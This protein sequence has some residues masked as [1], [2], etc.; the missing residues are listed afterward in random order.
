LIAEPWDVGQADSYDLG[1]FP[2]LWREWNGRYRD[3]VRDFLR[4]PPGGL[5]ELATRFRASA[6]LY[7]RPH[8]RP[9]PPVNLVTVHDG[10]TPA[11]TGMPGAD[12][13]DPSA[14]AVALYLDGSDAA[15]RAAD[16][17]WLADDDFLVVVNAWW[18]PLDFVLP[19]T[20]DGACWRPEINSYD[21][22]APA[23]P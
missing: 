15:D 9:A 2:P 3:T 21:L 17:T 13:A 1:R 18:E 10:V 14:L 12:W 7:A 8:P 19:V 6:E 5:G 22:A 11:G 16:G 23:G 4:S 20:R